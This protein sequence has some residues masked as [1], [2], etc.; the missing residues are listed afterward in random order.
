MPHALD[1]L[2]V[3]LQQ[4][5]HLQLAMCAE[6]E[7]MQ[8]LKDQR[9]VRSVLLGV[10]RKNLRKPSAKSALLGNHNSGKVHRTVTF[11]VWA[12]LP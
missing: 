6:K 3:M 11:A 1:V 4:R 9:D 7:G 2:L 12:G 5:R 8:A 10:S